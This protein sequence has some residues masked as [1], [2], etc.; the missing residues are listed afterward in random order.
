[1]DMVGLDNLSNLSNSVILFCDNLSICHRLYSA[2][3]KKEVLMS[4][5]GADSYF[6]ES[7]HGFSLKIFFVALRGRTLVHFPFFRGKNEKLGPYKTLGL[8]ST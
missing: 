2:L 1:M 7:A 5:G 6:C 8:P 4:S 3:T